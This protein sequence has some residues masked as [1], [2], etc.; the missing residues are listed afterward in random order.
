MY[1]IGGAQPEQL[2]TLADLIERDGECRVATLGGFIIAVW[3]TGV[4][5]IRPNGM[6]QDIDATETFG[7]W[8]AGRGG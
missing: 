2:R 5:A 4:V 1:D 3:R 8:D 7:D 6:M